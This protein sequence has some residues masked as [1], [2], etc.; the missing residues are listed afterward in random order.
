MDCYEIDADVEV[1]GFDA[2]GNRYMA[3]KVSRV[4]PG[5]QRELLDR[6]RDGDWQRDA[7]A[8]LLDEQEKV[9]AVKDKAQDAQHEE[10]A[11]HLAWALRK[12]FGIKRYF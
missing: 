12:D 1:F 7:M 3:C 10:A 11:E 8:A 4:N 9:Q 2:Q 6:L 5:W